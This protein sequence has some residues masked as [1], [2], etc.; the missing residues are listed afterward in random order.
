[1]SHRSSLLPLRVLHG[2]ESQPLVLT[3]KSCKA[4]SVSGTE[5]AFHHVHKV[6]LKFYLNMRILFFLK[7][8]IRKLPIVQTNSN[9]AC[10]AISIHQRFTNLA[11]IRRASMKWYVLWQ[12]FLRAICKAKNRTS[13]YGIIWLLKDLYLQSSLIPLFSWYLQ[14]FAYPG[15]CA[16]W[17]SWAI[18]IAQSQIPPF[19]IRI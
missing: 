15:I 10:L 14:C 12:T 13:T 11:I 4:W 3:S 17:N 16:P 18:A 8:L 5:L 6:S 1:M 2:S 7:V 19:D 9:L